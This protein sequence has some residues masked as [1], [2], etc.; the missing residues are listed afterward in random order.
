[1]THHH[2]GFTVYLSGT[3]GHQGNV[4]AHTYVRKI[5]KLIQVMNRLE[6][7]HEGSS[8]KKTDFEIVDAYKK[9]PTTLTLKPVPRVRDY[10]PAPA[11]D[12]SIAQLETIDRGEEPDQRIPS[13]TVAYLCG[14]FD[15][16]R[17]RQLGVGTAI[18]TSPR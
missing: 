16:Q 12:W 10:N 14:F 13:T 6:R 8:V 1:M 11:V 3:D 9:N 7:L 5:G 18:V 4:L 15:V 2:K 17:Q